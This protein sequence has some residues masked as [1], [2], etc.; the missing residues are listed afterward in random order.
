MEFFGTGPFRLLFR[1]FRPAVATF[2]EDD[3]FARFSAASAASTGDFDDCPRKSL[4]VLF[5]FTFFT[6]VP[7]GFVGAATAVPFPGVA[8]A[9]K[10]RMVFVFLWGCAAL[11]FLS[12]SSSVKVE[13]QQPSSINKD[14]A[15]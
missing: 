13:V 4:I 1:G 10:E 9:K 15:M 6:D 14:T 7:A 12:F 8:A 2:V 11:V 5:R 3:V